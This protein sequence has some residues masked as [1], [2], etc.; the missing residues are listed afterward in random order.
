MVLSSSALALYEFALT[1][2][3]DWHV[4]RLR[5]WTISAWLLVVTRILMV[6][7]VVTVPI[8]GTAQVSVNE[9]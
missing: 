5:K 7:Y 4:I 3:G 8:P 6:V 1:V 9:S 2:D